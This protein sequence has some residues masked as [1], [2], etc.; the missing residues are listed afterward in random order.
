ME[1]A[2][3]KHVQKL[4]DQTDQGFASFDHSGRLH[5]ANEV[6]KTFASAGK[7]L[8]W[9]DVC[10]NSSSWQQFIQDLPSPYMHHHRSVTWYDVPDQERVWVH[11]GATTVW[12]T[13]DYVGT[14]VWDSNVST[15]LWTNPPLLKLFACERLK[16]LKSLD[17]IKW[18]DFERDQPIDSPWQ[19]GATKPDDCVYC[20][21]TSEGAEPQYIR[22]DVQSHKDLSYL[23]CEDI[24]HHVRTQNKQRE[25]LSIASHEL[26]NP[27]TPLK[28]LLQLALAQLDAGEQLDPS[29]LRRADAQTSRLIRLTN[30]LLDVSRL[31]NQRF[32]TNLS[33]VDLRDVVDGIV[34]MWS[35][36]NQSHTFE[37][38]LS[39]RACSVEIDVSAIEQV[40]NNLIDNAIKFSPINST[41]DISLR[42][43]TSQALLSVTDQGDGI[44]P[45]LQRDIFSQFYRNPTHADTQGLGL[46]LYVTQNIVRELGGDV[47][48]DSSEGGP[49]SFT[50][51]IPTVSPS[52]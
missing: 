13:L 26:R 20:F 47:Y 40:I 48:V 25:L 5:F 12:R 38:S 30:T 24:T 29:L 6:A 8:S 46:G 19:P 50:I 32:T 31:D 9:T 23:V 21:R 42:T 37:L 18:S 51:A 34:D 3:I 36:H 49:T 15:V 10:S 11:I 22:A 4:L 1:D 16:A 35:T 27:L 14:M 39:T 41:I 44:P 7:P 45:E 28:G 43:F 17:H 2:Q 33:V 52:D